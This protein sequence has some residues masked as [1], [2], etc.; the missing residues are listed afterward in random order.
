MKSR[1]SP[2]ASVKVSFE[3]RWS[4][5]TKS[6]EHDV[7]LSGAKREPTGKRQRSSSAVL[8][9]LRL[10]EGKHLAGVGLDHLAEW[11]AVRQG[12]HSAMLQHR[13]GDGERRPCP[14]G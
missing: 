7:A 6:I 8:G 1:C 14:L 3:F 11:R 9:P 5:A 13:W 2:I 10:W 4:D 12:K